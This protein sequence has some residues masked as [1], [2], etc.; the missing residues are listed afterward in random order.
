MSPFVP[1][2]E[3]SQKQCRVYAKCTVCNAKF[4]HVMGYYTVHCCTLIQQCLVGE[5]RVFDLGSGFKNIDNPLL[6]LDFLTFPNFGT[7]KS[8]DSYTRE[9]KCSIPLKNLNHRILDKDDQ[10]RENHRDY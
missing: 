9:T 10:Q 5:R 3:T 4:K 2:H 7:K 1:N 8:H 6:V